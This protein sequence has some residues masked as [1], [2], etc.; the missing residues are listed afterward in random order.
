L[1][2]A[3]FLLS[4]YLAFA[5]NIIFWAGFGGSLVGV[6]L[7]FAADHQLVAPGDSFCEFDVEG[8]LGSEIWMEV[9]GAALCSPS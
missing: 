9:E 3:F 5:S 7:L 8:G 1:P 6:R 4:L 2:L